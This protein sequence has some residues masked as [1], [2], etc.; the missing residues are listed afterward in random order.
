MPIT[1]PVVLCFSG[2]DP[3]GGA[4]VQADIE[5][6]VSHRCHAAS[7]I[8][9]LTEQDTRNVKKLLPQ[10]PADIID[11][12]N[13]VLADLDVKAFKIGLIGHHETAAAIHAILQEH[14][15]IP[16]VLDPVLAAGGGAAVADR[17]LLDAIVDLLLPFTTVLTPNSYEA[18]KL[19]ELDDLDQCGLALLDKGCG[20]VLITGTHETTPK[21]SNR[22][23]HDRRCLETYHW[24]R[25]PENYHGSG[26]TL[27]ASIAGLIAQGLTLAQSIGEAQEYTWNALHHSYLPGKGQHNPDRLFWMEAGV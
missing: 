7:V 27:A 19:A 14:P 23:Y 6:L 20:Y 10:H 5:T 26:C 4:G 2:H 25:L 9:A 13:T 21:V 12:A 17:Q 16:V 1:R 18:R 22:L 8:T 15:H 11:Q 24:D 3:S